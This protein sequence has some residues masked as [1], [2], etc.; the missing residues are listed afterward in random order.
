MLAK[1][2]MGLIRAGGDGLP[3]ANCQLIARLCFAI[4]TSDANVVELV[5]A[6]DSKLNRN[7]RAAW[8][9]ITFEHLIIP[10]IT[11]V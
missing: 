2:V 3:V 11:G 7:R 6:L 5:D 4:S 8:L 1:T 10:K 9:F